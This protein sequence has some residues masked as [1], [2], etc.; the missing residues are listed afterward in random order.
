[1]EMERLG[2]IDLLTLLALARSVDGSYGVAVID[3]IKEFS[4]REVS[5]AAAYA[6]LER[7]EQRGLVRAAMSEPLPERG[8]RARR[9]Y[10]V[11]AGGRA[12]LRREREVAMRMWGLQ[13][14]EDD[15]TSW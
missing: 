15:S 7:L 2:E 4:G 12:R 8:G 6:A 10:R 11:T 1:M 14:L 3:A 9:H 5:V 13:S